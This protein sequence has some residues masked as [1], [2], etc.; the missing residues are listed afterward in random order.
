MSRIAF[1]INEIGRVM[2]GE[3][4]L[5]IRPA[6]TSASRIEV[7]AR[8]WVAEPFH[9]ESRFDAKAP[10]VA[11]SLGAV[12]GFSETYLPGEPQ[13]G[14]YG[15]RQPARSMCRDWHRAHV[16]VRSRTELRLR[17]LSAADL[18][19]LG[20]RTASSF[21]AQWDRQIS[22]WL[23]GMNWADNPAILKFAFELVPEPIPAEALT[24]LPRNRPSPPPRPERP[25]VISVKAA[26][27]FAD[28]HREVRKL[29]GSLHPVDLAPREVRSVSASAH[30]TPCL[31]S[32]AEREAGLCARCGSR[33]AFGC[34]HHPRQETA[35]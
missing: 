16:I 11:L 23:R 4:T 12:P 8:L 13:S 34:E 26:Q 19:N 17:D 29:S 21:A 9:L 30:L 24:P 25:A 15:K 32:L 7:G 27:D 20:H 22:E 35:A 33:L 31:P 10:T 5:F 3:Q 1:S 28:R 14:I 18:A 2:A 6:R